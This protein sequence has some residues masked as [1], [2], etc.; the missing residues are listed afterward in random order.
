MEE[1]GGL[2]SM[3]SQRVGHDWATSLWIWKFQN[4]KST[5][6]PLS[7]SLLESLTNKP[8]HSTLP[9]Y[10]GIR[11]I[12]DG[13]TC[14]RRDIT[15]FSVFFFFFFLD[16]S[17]MRPYEQLIG[18]SHFGYNY[19]NSGSDGKESACNT[20]DLGSTPGLGRSY[21]E[22]SGYPLQYSC[23]ENSMDSGAW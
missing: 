9:K 21:G 1:P 20:G 16:C 11:H 14:R 12:W 10:L 5:T 23:L 19:S 18:R 6:P 8:K 3:G 15:I 17:L 13:H 2:Q 7:K 22:G 4:V